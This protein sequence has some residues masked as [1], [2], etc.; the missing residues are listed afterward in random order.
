[1]T[2]PDTLNPYEQIWQSRD[3]KALEST[4][5]K[6]NN[7]RPEWKK[8]LN[9]FVDEMQGT[10]YG[11]AALASQGVENVVGPNDITKGITDWGLEGYNR[12][13]EESQAGVNAPKIARVEDVH[14]ASDAMDWASFQLGKGLPMLASL[15]VPAAIGGTIARFG[16]KEGVAA[17]AKSAVGDTVKKAVATKAL[18]AAEGDVV[19]DAM[20]QAAAKALQDRIAAGAVTGGYLGSFGLEGGQSF[21]ETVAQGVK[22]EDAVK[23]AI[24]VGGINGAL[25]FLPFYS[26]AKSIGLGQYAKKGIMDII[27]SDAG[28]AKKAVQ[29]AGELGGRAVKGGIVGAGAEG[30]TEGLQELTSI[31]G[32]RWAKNDPLFAD[33]SEDDWSRVKNSMA[34]G[35]L[36]GGTAMGAGAMLK[37]PR[38]TGTPTDDQQG[39]SSAGGVT[40]PPKTREQEIEELRNK[41]NTELEVAVKGGDTVKAEQL[42]SAR[43]KLDVA[44]GGEVVP[45]VQEAPVQE[46][47]AKGQSLQDRINRELETVKGSTARVEE[48]T[49][50]LNTIREDLSQKAKNGEVI[51][52]KQEQGLQL[53]QER[54][55]RELGTATNSTVRAKELSNIQEASTQQPPA[56]EVT[57]PP[58]DKP[59]QMQRGEEIILTPSRPGEPE[60]RIV[61]TEEEKV[62]L[63][64]LMGARHRRTPVQDVTQPDVIP[65]TEEVQAQTEAQ[66]RTTPRE[67]LP[68]E[69]LKEDSV[70]QVEEFDKLMP[71]GWK[72][73]EIIDSGF[74]PTP[75]WENKNNP[76]Q[77][78]G[79][80]GD[81]F[82]WSDDSGDAKIFESK[83]DL[84]NF[85]NEKNKPVAN[86]TLQQDLDKMVKAVADGLDFQKLTKV[87]NGFNIGL[88]TTKWDMDYDN[89][90]VILTSK[91]N[92]TTQGA[93]PLWEVVWGG[94]DTFSFNTKIN[95][96][97]LI[98]DHDINSSTDTANILN[99]VD[100]W[101]FAE[102]MADVDYGMSTQE[103]ENKW[104]TDIADAVYEHKYN[105]ASI[106]EVISTIANSPYVDIETGKF[107]SPSGAS[108]LLSYIHSGETPPESLGGAAAKTLVESGFSPNTVE[109]F[110]EKTPPGWKFSWIGH[111]GYTLTGI[112]KKGKDSLSIGNQDK[113]I[114]L[115]QNGEYTYFTSYPELLDYLGTK[116]DEKLLE[117]TE[118]STIPAEWKKDGWTLAGVELIGDKPVAT[119][120]NSNGDSFAAQEI[121]GPKY[122]DKNG[123]TFTEHFHSYDDMMEYLGKPKLSNGSANLDVTHS[124]SSTEQTSP[125][126]VL[127]GEWAPT[128]LPNGY[129]TSSSHIYTLDDTEISLP[130]SMSDKE[131]VEIAHIHQY[132]K[133]AQLPVEEKI[134]LFKELPTTV[135]SLNAFKAKHPYLFRKAVIDE[136]TS[137]EQAR[138][139][140]DDIVTRRDKYTFDEILTELTKFKDKFGEEEFAATLAKAP[141]NIVQSP[142]L[143]GWLTN[144]RAEEDLLSENPFDGI[145]AGYAVNSGYSIYTGKTEDASRYGVIL[146]NPKTG[147]VL[148]RKVANQYEGI[149]W[150]FARGGAE[151]FSDPNAKP[152]LIDTKHSDPNKRYMEHPLIA[153]KREAREEFGYDVKV[154]G[155]MAKGFFTGNHNMASLYYVA[156]PVSEQTN[157]YL[158][159]TH[160]IKE[161]DETRWVDLHEARKLV[162]TMPTLSN[163]LSMKR[164]GNHKPRIARIARTLE[165][166]FDPAMQQSDLDYRSNTVAMK[167][168]FNSKLASEFPKLLAK[169]VLN[170]P[171]ESLTELQK[172][173][174][175]TALYVSIRFPNADEETKAALQK[176]LYIKRSTA[177]R[178]WIQKRLG[179]GHGGISSVVEGTA[180]LKTIQSTLENTGGKIVMSLWHGTKKTNELM[181]GD[182]INPLYLNSGWGGN[183]TKS[184]V[185]LADSQ[186]KAAAWGSKAQINILVA[187]ENL[188]VIPG[189]K[190]YDASTFTSIIEQAK[191]DGFDG[192]F[193]NDV[194]DYVNGRQIV[195]WNAN[196]ITAAGGVGIGFTGKNLYQSKGELRERMSMDTAKAV[197]DDT[198]GPVAQN[199]LDSGLLEFV[200]SGGPDGVAGQY[201]GDEQKIRVYLDYISS[202]R[203]LIGAVLHE[204]SH[205]G[206]REMLG[207][208]AEAYHKDLVDSNT[209]A[210][211][212]AMY[213]TA[214]E[215]AYRF[216]I[217]NTLTPANATEISRVREELKKIDP[218]FLIEEDLANFVQQADVQSTLWQR[219]VNAIK[220]WWAKSAI[221]KA[222]KERGFGFALTEDMAVGL[223]TAA[224]RSQS[225]RRGEDYATYVAHVSGSDW[226]S[227]ANYPFGKPSLNFVLAGG[228]EGYINYGWGIYA[229]ESQA[230]LKYYKSTIGSN[231]YGMYLPDDIPP[232]LIEWDRPLQQQSSIVK[233]AITDSRDN[234]FLLRMAVKAK[235]RKTSY[236]SGSSKLETYG[237]GGSLYNEIRDYYINTKYNGNS[238]G[239][240]YDKETKKQQ[241][242]KNMARRDAS[243]K[244]A[245]YGIA[246][247]RLLDAGSREITITKQS[248][249]NYKIVQGAG[250]TAKIQVLSEENLEKHVGPDLANAAR[251]QQPGEPKIH[252][253]F[254]FYNWVFWRQSDLDRFQ[255]IYKNGNQVAPLPKNNAPYDPN[256]IGIPYAEHPGFSDYVI[257][258]KTGEASFSLPSK[259]VEVELEDLRTNIDSV[260]GEGWLAQAEA[261]G[262]VQVIKGAGPR[263][264]AGSWYKNKIRLYTRSMPAGGSPI[265]VL[266]HEGKHATFKDVLGG[267]LNSYVNDLRTLANNGNQAARDAIIHATVAA[268]DLLGI[269]HGFKDKESTTDLDSTRAAIEELKPG[270]LAEEEL[271]YF[272]QYGTGQQGGAGFLKRL[273]NAIKAWFAQTQL[274]KALKEAGLGFELT[275]G[276]AVEW[277][278]MGLHKSLAKVRQDGITQA[279]VLQQAVNMPPSVRLG[280]A[281]EAAYQNDPLYSIGIQELKDAAWTDPTDSRVEMV[282]KLGLLQRWRA[283]FID[284]FAEIE[285]KSKTVYDAF[286]LL[287]NKVAAR[288]SQS[289]QEYYLPLLKEIVGSKWTAKQVGDMLAARHH[290][291]DKVNTRLAERASYGYTKEL[292]KALPKTKRQELMEGRVHI[293]AGKMPDGKVY[294]INGVPATMSAVTKQKFMFDLM[295]KYSQFEI[296]DANGKQALREE[297]EIFKDAA[298]GFSDG[299][300]AKDMVRTV[301]EVLAPASSDQARFDRIAALF[302][303]MNRHALQIREDGGLITAAEHARLLIDKS[304]YAPLK[305]ESYNVNSET[306]RLF[307]QAGRGGNKNLGTRAGTAELSEPT[308]VLQNALALLEASAAAAERNLANQELYKVVNAD[309]AAWKPWF[310]IAAKDEYVTHDEDGF[311]Q[312]KNSTAV[313]RADIVL[314]KDGKKIVIR[315]NMHNDRAMGFVRAANN[316]DAQELSGPMKVLGMFNNLVRAVNIAFSP[317]FLMMNAI[318]DPLTAA[319]N[320]QATEG[321]KHTGEIFVKDYFK[322]YRDSFR[323]LKKVFMDGN[324]DRTDAD[325]KWVERYENAGGRTSFIEQLKENDNTWR[326]F[327][328]QVAR[329]Q[330]N[331]KHLMAVKDTWIDGIENLN[332]L[333]ENVMR[334]S[335]FRVLVEKG[336]SDT[337]AARIAQ[338]LTTNFSRRG[339]KSQALGLWWLFFNA[340]VQGNY[341]VVRNLMKSKRLQV[342]SLGTIA[343]AVMLDLLGR[344]IADD[345]D[346]IPEWD[347]ERFIIIPVKV[348]GD[349]VKIPA[350]WVYNTLWRT[351]GLIGEMFSG[352]KEPQDALLDM[353]AMTATTFNPLGKPG[354]IAQAIAPTAADPFIQIL[355]NKD[356]AGNPIGP[357]GYPGASKKANSELL[358]SSTP[359]GYQS[360]ARFVNEVTGGSATE[361]G[362]I[363]L[364]PGDYQLLAKFLTGS[365]GRFLTDSTF[366]FAEDVKKGIEGPKDIPVIREFFSDPY[367]PLT[368]Q[369]YHTNIASIYGA[370]RLERM[371]REGPDRDLIKLQEVRSERGEELRMY[372][373]AQD[374]E[375][376]LKSLRVRLKAAQARDDVGREKQLKE[377][378][379]Q[380]QEQFNAAYRQ[381]VN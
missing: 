115:Y 145:W 173:R 334:F 41:I 311:L 269:K 189:K 356:F 254:G 84:T 316:L 55:N 331:F 193:F 360:I 21:G 181:I 35:A 278:K 369:K 353:A 332:I 138:T 132:L 344:A 266:L 312:E 284:F 306:A 211:K 153:A 81:K 144:M 25:E 341:Q 268:A 182:A 69:Q 50:T 262:I 57:P 257:N 137:I 204:G 22:P 230:A 119:Y 244:L 6:L 195:V 247:V 15:A 261:A 275:E 372:S 160:G 190:H 99:N 330:G 20:K 287:R 34:A 154:I 349:Y 111:D 359:K 177:L 51:S 74:G 143:D 98:E 210:S 29:L 358:W 89:E 263:N 165:A 200:E 71:E 335:T 209:V 374:V 246:G 280:R 27:K 267:S 318:K 100:P 313:N 113:T 235:N 125:P 70:T 324:R 338:D 237:T 326:S 191:K 149:T 3:L 24:A 106:D 66:V 129:T 307:Q 77:T 186:S 4:P 65:N 214:W 161:T 150:D 62:R 357:E 1:M 114:W 67:I 44:L 290:K 43:D 146:I 218:Y 203:E 317:I 288:L 187:F 139:M 180:S 225:S 279:K 222:L 72:L 368:V 303:A 61:P 202:P 38:K 155:Q 201:F 95:G 148:L 133:Y 197:L 325:V 379:A 110:A 363:D 141:S 301:D 343:F 213:K 329:R 296:T 219:L 351:G 127:S 371:Y 56:E 188:K 364:K 367:D 350:P 224:L 370:H 322:T 259:T 151:R 199:L 221:G 175:A 54:I 164:D 31:A 366:G 85:L 158:N 298:G 52:Q 251:K 88:D 354:S 297:W 207:R 64:E 233:D 14:T 196:N 19:T 205:A 229:L 104:G 282:N 227:I 228:G 9:A 361:S 277:A 157:E 252:A 63:Q 314:I 283:D 86:P 248:D 320:L 8:G 96:K 2:T 116:V 260:M 208:S 217:A 93:S 292:L 26:A 78:V 271:A 319:Y 36:V 79:M 168:Y 122:L 170:K 304:A 60:A 105:N 212:S 198:F 375:R 118:L 239:Y 163:D 302:D 123:V 295:N 333:F 102:L 48:L 249:G 294:T 108:S 135:D 23:S 120:T 103:I 75:F 381:R 365:M 243:R 339:Y 40:A 285:K 272:V 47:P 124:S 37:G 223:A 346:E 107:P 28:L 315:P 234:Y 53:L 245:E 321:A 194:D 328:A 281:L 82:L 166:V 130:Y 276:M 112:Y 16:A 11:L 13:M 68:A 231:T 92:K 17:L 156:V 289:R 42:A 255:I 90:T 174:V 308:N 94:G 270:L 172:M 323:M 131:K 256:G 378:M 178:A 179:K 240:F 299:G 242:N 45:P 109:S 274:G 101:V 152:Y 309:K 80:S 305:R 162:T 264:E 373:Q 10:G 18:Q 258:P 232:R 226:P 327:D 140:L 345:W 253:G 337:D 310:H 117:K 121:D 236:P 176:E 362:G 250:N 73:S 355:E 185:F 128:E 300:V 46:T 238:Y 171:F 183:D 39:G 380:V 87:V 291:V 347:K 215:G 97:Y 83:D 377:R 134:Q 184:G 7:K 159:P 348:D 241:K 76:G 220:V 342:L 58:P 30:I 376:Q 32:E 206:M 336:M 192:V 286:T 340:S 142:H 293:K 91:P 59:I 147:K 216:G 33:L 5:I 12:N 136:A 49:N 265:G 352:V 126:E 273:I 167:N 169:S